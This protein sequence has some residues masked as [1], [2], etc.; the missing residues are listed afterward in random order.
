MIVLRIKQIWGFIY[1]KI[2]QFMYTKKNTC[3]DLEKKTLAVPQGYL[4]APAFTV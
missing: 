2:C 4:M 3:I 1:L